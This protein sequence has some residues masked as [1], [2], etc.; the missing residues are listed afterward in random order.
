MSRCVRSLRRYSSGSSS[1]CGGGGSA[2][3]GLSADGRRHP[4]PGAGAAAAPAP[5]RASLQR[6][7]RA[8]EPQTGGESL[9]RDRPRTMTLC[10]KY[11]RYVNSACLRLYFIKFSSW[12]QAASPYLWRRSSCSG[13]LPYLTSALCNVNP[14]SATS[15]SIWML[16][17]DY[18][19]FPP[20]R[21]Y[22]TLDYQLHVCVIPWSPRLL[23]FSPPSE[24]L[25]TGAGSA[26]VRRSGENSG[27]S[28]L[29]PGRR[30]AGLPVPHVPS[31]RRLRLRTSQHREPHTA[32][33][34]GTG[35]G[36]GGHGPQL[37]PPG[38]RQGPTRA[39]GLLAMGAVWEGSGYGSRKQG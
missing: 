34:G 5:A 29:L 22:M 7:G 20:S 26:G 35:P 9:Q 28:R 33:P 37:K 1:A 15:L 12:L 14:F 19:L 2:S 8:P 13:E 25:A 32:G 30:T 11:D 24:H 4:A 10:S 6:G 21:L 27:L 38:G 18:F 23:N 31:P 17:A 39:E 36:R 3:A 16:S